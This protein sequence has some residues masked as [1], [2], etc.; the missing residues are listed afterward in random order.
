MI[1]R[2]GCN[3]LVEGER[4][5]REGERSRREVGEKWERSGREVGERGRGGERGEEREK[6]EN[7]YDSKYHKLILLMKCTIME[8]TSDPFSLG[9]E[10]N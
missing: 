3:E 8:K 9:G 7:K 4:R 10:P 6:K 5:G 1:M 2:G